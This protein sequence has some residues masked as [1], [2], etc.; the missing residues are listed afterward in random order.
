MEPC[1]PSWMG[2]YTPRPCRALLENLPIII[3]TVMTFRRL[4]AGLPQDTSVQTG[5]LQALDTWLAED[6]ARVEGKLTQRDAVAALVDLYARSHQAQE[7]Q[8][9]D[10]DRGDRSGK[11]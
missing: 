6:L 2:M 1:K 4:P 7:T 11:M 9:I 3:S 8:V 10:A 5:V